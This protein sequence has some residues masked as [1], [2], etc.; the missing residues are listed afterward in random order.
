MI[1][2]QQ[3][4]QHDPHALMV[5]TP[6]LVI[7]DANPA[8]LAKLDATLEAI[9]GRP[10]FDAFPPRENGAMRQARASLEEVLRTGKPHTLDLLY[11]P[12]LRQMPD[13]Q[14][15]EDRFWSITNTPILGADGSVSHILHCVTDVTGLIDPGLGQPA[16]G[17]H[18]FEELRQATVARR[19]NRALVSERSHLRHLMQ[20]APGFVAVGRGPEHVFELANEA[21]YS[22]VGHRDILGKPV[23]HALPELEGQGFFELLD[24]V[25]TTGEP[26][27][28]RAMPV[29]LRPQAD[30]PTVEHHIDFI[31]QPILDDAGEVS[32]V[33]VQG[34]DVSEAYQLSQEV[35]YQAAHDALTGLANRREFERCLRIAIDELEGEAMHSVLY[36]DLDQFKIVNDTCGHSAGDELLRHVSMILGQQVAP[37]DTLAGWAAT[38]SACCFAIARKPPPSASPT[39]CARWCRRSSSAGRSAC[40]PA[41][42]ASAWPASGPASATLNRCSAPRI[43]PASWPRKRAATACRCTAPKTRSWPPAGARWTGRC[44]CARRCARTASSSTSRPWCRCRRGT[45]PPAAG[46]ADPPARRGRQPGAADGLH[47]GRRALRHH[48]GHR[49]LGDHPRPG[50]P[51]AAEPGP[52]RAHPAV[53]QPVRRHA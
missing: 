8:Y 47:P 33:F 10:V 41:A 18:N 45:A 31:Y 38:S 1:D 7:V 16:D 6:D 49:P 34:H 39:S 24:R 43:P 25:Y 40:S 4:F 51:R 23:R 11:F 37:H 48:A 44:A 14:V 3:T 29:Q 46:G 32:G 20:Q 52:R 28:G 2:Y 13:G 19:I 5:L 15:W 53:D 42:S 12:V 35:S 36:L 17:Q 9:K 30:G 50:L 27:I 21:Y 22:L 26:F